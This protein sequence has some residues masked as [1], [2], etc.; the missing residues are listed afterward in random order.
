MTKEQEVHRTS[1]EIGIEVP[2]VA[3]QLSKGVDEEKWKYEQ[4]IKNLE[5]E[6]E[7]QEM[8]SERSGDKSVPKNPWMSSGHIQGSLGCSEYPIPPK[9]MSCFLDKALPFRITIDSM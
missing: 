3:D 5:E 4:S 8:V 7:N 1:Y 9:S 2:F 6:K